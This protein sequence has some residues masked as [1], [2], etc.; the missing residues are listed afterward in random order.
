MEGG[1][2]AGAGGEGG[3]RDACRTRST[4]TYI[5][6]RNQAPCMPITATALVPCHAHV[7]SCA[8]AAPGSRLQVAAASCSW[9]ARAR[10]HTR[11]GGLK[12]ICAAMVLC[13]RHMAWHGAMRRGVPPSLSLPPSMRPEA[14]ALSKRP[15]RP[16]QQHHTHFAAVLMWRDRLCSHAPGGT[17]SAHIAK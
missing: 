15:Q 11:V 7:T 17:C 1:G 5:H 4:H 8:P 13:M 2:G 14:L 10:T 12:D 3:S 6:M 9:H 16:L